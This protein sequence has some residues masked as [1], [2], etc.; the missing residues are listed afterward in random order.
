MLRPI[1]TP[2]ALNEFYAA[3]VQAAPAISML[4]LGSLEQSCAEKR[5]LW[6]RHSMADAEVGAAHMQGLYEYGC[7]PA[8]LILV[9]TRSILALLQ[10]GLE[11]ARTAGL[12]AV[13]IEIWGNAAAYDLTASR[14]LSLAAKA[15]GVT[16]AVARVAAPPQPSAADMRWLV[17]PLPSCPLQ[18]RAPGPP[19]FALSLLR[20][21]C[22][23]EG[24]SYH[25]EWN[26]DDRRF[27]ILDSGAGAHSGGLSDRAS[28]APLPG[29]LVSFPSSGAAREALR[30][31]G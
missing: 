23:R 15:S 6:A 20:A 18:A 28:I 10:A 8:R 4:V 30:R 7:N 21:R 9:R 11:G 17:E 13:L 12:G 25:L 14:R 16:L 27:T 5:I 29:A 3:R 26:R 19:R 31:A 24:L 22:G 1:M 2:M